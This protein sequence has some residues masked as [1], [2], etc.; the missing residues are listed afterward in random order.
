MMDIVHS[1]VY[2]VDISRLKSADA[3]MEFFSDKSGTITW[4][5]KWSKEAFQEVYN[6]YYADNDT[7]Q[8]DAAFHY[9]AP[10]IL[11]TLELSGDEDDETY[12][13]WI[14]HE[15]GYRLKIP[16]CERISSAWAKT[17]MSHTGM[18]WW[19]IAASGAYNSFAAF[20]VPRRNLSL[21]SKK[22]RYAAQ[23]SILVA[24]AGVWQYPFYV[25]SSAS[26]VSP[27]TETGNAQQ[28]RFAIDAMTKK[29]HWLPRNQ[30]DVDPTI[31]N[32][33][34]VETQDGN[35]INLFEGGDMAGGIYNSVPAVTDSPWARNVHVP[36]HPPKGQDVGQAQV[37]QDVAVDAADYLVAT[38]Y[39]YTGFLGATVLSDLKV[40]LNL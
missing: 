20:G 17:G 9:D 26:F 22:N 7:F 13:E 31:L 14:Y 2:L 19:D 4:A 40:A 18:A 30:E 6:S 16:G 38:A 29:E 21:S 12:R 37:A 27:T 8:A 35:V 5:E 10:E 24:V 1:A 3:A 39:Y 33:H 34:G 23:P 11:D 36:T 15:T 28:P 32:V 25:L